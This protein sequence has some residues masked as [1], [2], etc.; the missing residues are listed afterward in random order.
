MLQLIWSILSADRVVYN[1]Y[2]KVTLKTRKTDLYNYAGLG[3]SFFFKLK[4]TCSYHYSQPLTH[5]FMSKT[6]ELYP[7]VIL[8]CSKTGVRQGCPF[9]K[10]L[11]LFNVCNQSITSY[12][13][14]Y[15]FA[16]T[17]SYDTLHSYHLHGSK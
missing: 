7:I 13:Y 2:I 6:S 12:L 10:F 17:L 11:T 16:K 9:L 14:E 15:H 4:L 5:T 3:R 1:L 8:F